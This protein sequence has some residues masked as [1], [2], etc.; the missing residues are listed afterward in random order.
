MKKIGLFL[1]ACLLASGASSQGY[2][3]IIPA[4]V[5]AEILHGKGTEWGKEVEAC[6]DDEFSNQIAFIKQLFQQELNI[7]INVTNNRKATLRFEYDKK[8]ITPAEHY[9]IAIGFN[10]V[11]VSAASVRGIVNG[12]VSL[13]QLPNERDGRYF[14]QPENI[15]DYP[16]YS[17]RGLH[18]DVVRHIFPLE[19]IKKYIDYITFH[20][21]NTFHWHLTDDQGWRMEVLSY[22]KLNSIGSWRD[23]T[24]IGHFKDTPIK[25][26]G[27]RYGGFY[28]RDQ[29]KEVLAYAKE[30]GI[31]VIPE[32]DIPGHSRATIAAYPELSTKPDTT[33]NVAQTWGMYNRQN[34][35]LAPNDASFTF[36]NTIFKELIELFPS[37]Y[38]HIGGDECSKLWWKQDPKTKEFMKANG[39]KDEVALQTYF[40]EKVAGD[41]KGMGRKVIGWHEIAEG[42]VDTTTLIMNWADDKKAIEVAQKG[43]SVIQTP[44]KPFYFDHYQSLTNKDSLAIHGFNPVDSV[45]NYSLVPASIRKA[46]LAHKVIGGQANVWTEYMGYSTKVDYMIFPRVTALAENLW[47]TNKNYADFQRR[48]K[49]YMYKRYERWG[50][51]YFH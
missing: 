3:K 36:L 11:V 17:Y 26:D 50:S 44:G 4:V 51:S 27:T 41:V 2:E 9:N 15:N 5:H 46:G 23:Q 19:Y 49:E 21:L 30:R 12:I 6:V 33:W 43:F 18:L 1:M 47:G 24:L 7:S 31:E 20:K 29:I 34:N 45:Y 38:I 28:T 32:I 22:P 42:K 37:T 8:L 14:L 35:V 10:Q 25:Y 13:V 40:I 48:L 16:A 39:I